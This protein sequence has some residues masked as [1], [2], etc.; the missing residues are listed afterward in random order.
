ME[1]SLGPDDPRVRARAYELWERDGRPDNRHL[2]HWAQAV[3][4]IAEEDAINGPDAGLQ[5]PDN[6]ST[7]ILR[8]AAEHLHGKTGR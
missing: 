3:R 4:E 2:A 6:A 5:V 1:H 8:E 7:R